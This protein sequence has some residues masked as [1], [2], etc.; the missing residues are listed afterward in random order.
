MFLAMTA[1]VSKVV[2]DS[3]VHILHRSQLLILHY[4]SISLQKLIIVLN[5]KNQSL[6][7][8]L[9]VAAIIPW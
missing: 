3:D 2:G 1:A 4:F 8:Q 9:R 6:T 5:S 7:I